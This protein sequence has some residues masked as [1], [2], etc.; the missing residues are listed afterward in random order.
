[1]DQYK[2]KCHHFPAL[3]TMPCSVTCFATPFP[4]HNSQAEL[5]QG[6]RAPSLSKTCSAA[7][8]ASKEFRDALR[9]MF[10]FSVPCNTTLHWWKEWRFSQLLSAS[11][12]LPAQQDC[13]ALCCHLSQ[14]LSCPAKTVELHLLLLRFHLVL[15]SLCVR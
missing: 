7:L 6:L 12:W 8:V 3:L 13:S 5:P 4:C 11:T 1:M 15:Y 10:V 9:P 14:L 2:L